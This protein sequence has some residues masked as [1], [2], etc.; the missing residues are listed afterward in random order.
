ME[1]AYYT[2]II[3][4]IVYYILLYYSI[5]IVVYYIILYYNTDADILQPPQKSTL[6]SV[7]GHRLGFVGV[8]CRKGTPSKGYRSSA[9][10]LAWLMG[11]GFPKS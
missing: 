3:F 2:H 9:G 1:K 11:Q 8:M 10:F 5:N 4:I 6:K 7:F